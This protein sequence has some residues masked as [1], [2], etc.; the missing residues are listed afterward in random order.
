MLQAHALEEDK[1]TG[2]AGENQKAN[3]L[4]RVFLALLNVRNRLG[5]EAVSNFVCAQG[6]AKYIL[7]VSVV[8]LKWGGEG[9]GE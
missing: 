2:E 6:D 1:S 3:S 4:I 9:G 7:V 8:I 5:P